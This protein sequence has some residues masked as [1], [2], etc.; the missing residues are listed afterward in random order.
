MENLFVLRLN[1]LVNTSS[2]NKS[3]I[4]KSVGLTYRG[5]H[6]YLKGEREPSLSVAC[7]LADYFNVSLDYLCGRSEVK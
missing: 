6:F 4:A 7:A 5:L 1:E 3:D 2:K